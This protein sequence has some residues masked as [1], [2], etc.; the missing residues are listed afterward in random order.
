MDNT[1]KRLKVVLAKKK[2]TNKWLAEK[3]H[4]VPA[5]GR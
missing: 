5:T 2:Q 3:L 4:R 1:L